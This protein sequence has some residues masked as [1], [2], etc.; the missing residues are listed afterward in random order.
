VVQSHS[1]APFSHHG[2]GSLPGWAS[3]GP[4]PSLWTN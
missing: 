1:L 2:W 3:P 4:F